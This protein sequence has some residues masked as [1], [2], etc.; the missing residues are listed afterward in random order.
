[1]DRFLDVDEVIANACTRIKN[2]S[3]DDMLTMRQWVW[4]AMRSI[5]PS[6]SHIEVKDVNIFNGQAKKPRDLTGKIIDLS[7]YDENNQEIPYRYNYDGGVIHQKRSRA[8]R[9]KIDIYE[10]AH[11]INFSDFD[12][13]PKYVK[14]KYF[15]MPLDDCD[16]PLVPEDHLLAIVYFLMY[17]YY[18]SEGSNFG[19]IGMIS[20]K[21]ETERARI[22]SR[23]RSMAGVRFKQAAR[24]W[25]SMIPNSRYDREV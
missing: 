5:G 22:M 17:T 9:N 25:M 16:L 24:E 7:I 14:I 12:I 10:D 13:T 15:K 23:N 21:W 8:K 4:D 19:M 3:D 6:N 18:L 2:V 1:M 11:F 20:S